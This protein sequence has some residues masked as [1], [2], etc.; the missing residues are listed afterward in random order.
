MENLLWLILLFSTLHSDKLCAP[1]FSFFI[2][3]EWTFFLQRFTF[4]FFA[5]KEFI[6]GNIYSTCSTF[7]WLQPVLACVFSLFAEESEKVSHRSDS[8][9]LFFVVR[10]LS[11]L[12]RPGCRSS[13]VARERWRVWGENCTRCKASRREG[14]GGQIFNSIHF[15]DVLTHNMSQLEKKSPSVIIF[16]PTQLFWNSIH[17][18]LS[19]RQYWPIVMSQ[20]EQQEPGVCPALLHSSCSQKLEYRGVFPQATISQKMFFFPITPGFPNINKWT[21]RKN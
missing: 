14:F 16:E 8:H 20:R 17:I 15:M 3:Y 12:L 6:N 1:E 5:W 7:Y 9:S 4:F 10:L 21:L 18:K 11:T 13:S 2:F 19:V